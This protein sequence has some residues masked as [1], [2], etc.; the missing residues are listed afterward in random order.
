MPRTAIDAFW[1]GQIR[2]IVANSPKLGPGPVLRELTRIGERVG[3]TDWP[4][5]RTVG[6]EQQRFRAAGEAEQ[7]EYLEFH[8]PATMERGDLPWEASAVG[9][10]LLRHLHA[11]N[12]RSPFAKDGRPLVSTVRWLWYVTLARPTAS[13]A[14]RL[15]WARDLALSAAGLVDCRLDIE[16]WIVTGDQFRGGDFFGEIVRSPFEGG[17][18][19]DQRSIEILDGWRTHV[20]KDVEE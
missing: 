17:V 5:E 10:E 12:V 11:G 20:A 4:S 15:W 7:R 8:W 19:L 2:S 18:A 14:A 16:S 6:R 1:R 13:L 3:R 9:I